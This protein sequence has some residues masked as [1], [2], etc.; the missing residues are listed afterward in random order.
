MAHEE[1][2]TMGCREDWDKSATSRERKERRQAV[3]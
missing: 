2:A 1:E 3:G